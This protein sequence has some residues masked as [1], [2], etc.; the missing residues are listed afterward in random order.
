MPDREEKQVGIVISHLFKIFGAN[1]N[2]HL[3]ALA[4]GMTKDE[5]NERHGLVLGLNDVSINMAAGQVH[6]IM[7]LSGSG[8]STLI[9]HI[10]RLVEPTAGQIIVGGQD[11]LKLDEHA[12]RAFRRNTTAMVFQKFA[13]LPHR[14]VLE[15]TLYGLEIQ[16]GD[17]YRHREKAMRWISRV[18]LNGFENRYP[19]QLSGGMQ[20]RVG[21]ARA[22]ASDSPILLMDEAFSALDPLI[23]SD[24]Q[25]M[26]RNIQQ[27]VKKTIVFITHDL[28]EALRL[29]DQIAI[30]RNG[31]IVQ[32]GSSQDIVL[33]PADDYVASFVKD[34]NRGRIIR[35]DAIMTPSNPASALPKSL[36]SADTTLNAA[37]KLMCQHGGHESVVVDGHGKPLGRVTK[38]QIMAAMI[39]YGGLWGSENGGGTSSFRPVLYSANQP[40]NPGNRAER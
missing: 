10:N 29:G 27:E 35:V 21:L 31:Q 36:L 19:N 22:L 24:M 12:L 6:V 16:G 25:E 20:Q 30:L 2:N 1:A 26:L 3:N 14:N 7:G 18:G 38:D 11:V 39:G 32:Q 8:K 15:N 5:L 37:A 34:V 13:L 23:R 9:R 28:D 40:A 4:R 33:R 17:R